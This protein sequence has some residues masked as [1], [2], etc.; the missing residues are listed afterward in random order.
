MK[1]TL[2]PEMQELRRMS[3]LYLLEGLFIAA[4]FPT[5]LIGGM[6]ALAG[7]FDED[8]TTKQTEPSEPIIWYYKA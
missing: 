8:I 5:T 6:S 3:R 1:T 7:Y 4:M 2:N